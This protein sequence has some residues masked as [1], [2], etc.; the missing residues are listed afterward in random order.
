MK[1]TLSFRHKLLLSFLLISTVPLFIVS[2][3]ILRESNKTLEKNI[4]DSNL[5]FIKQV[6]INIDQTVTRVNDLSLFIF[7]NKDIYNFLHLPPDVSTEES[8]RLTLN[9]YRTLTFFMNTGTGITSIL[10]EGENGLTFSINPMNY[11]QDVFTEDMLKKVDSLDGEAFWSQISS[12][13][14]AQ[15]RLIKDYYDLKRDLGHVSIQI[16]V[17][18][19]LKN[20]P[21]NNG[22]SAKKIYIFRDDDQVLISSGSIPDSIQN[23]ILPKISLMRLKSGYFYD[24]LND[25]QHLTFFTVLPSSDI[26]LIWTIPLEKVGLYD[27]LLNQVSIVTLT[28][29]LVSIIMAFLFSRSFFLPLKILGYSMKKVENEQFEI[30]IPQR[31]ND[32]IGALISSFNNMAERLDELHN[33]VYVAHVKEKEAELIALETQI[34]PHFLYN[35]LDTIYWM[36]KLEGSFESAQMIK[37]LADLF[38]I[39]LSSGNEKI[40]LKKELEHLNYYMEIQMKRFGNLFTFSLQVDP[41]LEE[42]TVLKLILQPLVENAIVHGIEKKQGASKI[43]VSIT[44]DNEGLLIYR[45]SDDGAGFNTNTL[46][47]NSGDKKGGFGLRNVDERLR[48]AYGPEYGILVESTHGEGTTIVIRQPL[49][50]KT[51]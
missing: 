26:T 15:S 30:R 49:K 46:K 27:L 44:A 14:V 9:I 42:R 19:I 6:G 51:E 45:V 13:L 4:I 48:L 36:T 23:E 25:T 39:A 21:V 10:I 22:E 28:M 47:Q 17:D 24:E 11:N 41:E 29:I 35:T 33:E 38:R 8:D 34:N 7:Q 37:T 20:F 1:G 18:E 32:E 40:P 43:D 2:M 50:D 16:S 12:D 5:N 31:R 3:L